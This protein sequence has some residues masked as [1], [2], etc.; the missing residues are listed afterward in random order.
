MQSEQRVNVIEREREPLAKVPRVVPAARRG[1]K[2]SVCVEDAIVK[3]ASFVNPKY[4]AAAALSAQKSQ[5]AR[6]DTIV[7]PLADR[8]R[9]RNLPVRFYLVAAAGLEAGEVRLPQR[10]PTG[11][12]LIAVRLD[13]GQGYCFQGKVCLARDRKGQGSA[14]RIRL[15]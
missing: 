15:R 10:T 14:P 4:R 8:K 2:R 1:P 6:R 12:E 9:R 7:D 13:V 11:L 5:I 3:M